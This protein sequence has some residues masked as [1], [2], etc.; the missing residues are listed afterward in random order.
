MSKQIDQ[1]YEPTKAQI[2][3]ALLPSS[4]LAIRNMAVGVAAYYLIRTITFIN[5]PI[6]EISLFAF[7][8]VL[9][10]AIIAWRC[11]RGNYSPIEQNLSSVALATALLGNSLFN[12]YINQDSLQINLVLFAI[13]ATTL[14]TIR[15][16]VFVPMFILSHLGYIYLIADVPSDIRQFFV[17][18][19]VAEMTIS[20]VFFSSRY[21]AL[22]QQVR[23][24]LIVD[25]KAADL[26][27]TSAAKDVF[28]ANITH[29]LRTPLTG[30]VGTIDLLSET[31]LD[32]EQRYLASVAKRSARI[33]LTL[34]NDILDLAKLDDGKL[35]IKPSAVDPRK[36]TQDVHDTLA[37]LAADK[38]LTFDIDMP[39]DLPV[40]LVDETRLGQI[41]FNLIGNA[42]KYTAS[43]GIFVEFHAEKSSD[44]LWHC[45]W[46][47]KDT[48]PGIDDHARHRLFQRY[49]QFDD[50]GKQTVNTGTG[51]GLSISR[52]LARNMGGDVS[53]EPRLPGGSCFALSLKLP[54]A[55][56][57]DVPIANIDYRAEL[58]G[59]SVK[60][61]LAEDTKINQM[62]IQK[63]L[64]FD[65][66]SFDVAND[67]REAVDKVAAGE[68]YDLILMDIIM[69]E[70]DGQEATKQILAM[71]PDAVIV[72][73]SANVGG[74]SE[75]K[76]AG[77]GFKGSISKPINQDN[78]YE[79]LAETLCKSD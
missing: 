43:G 26:E 68:V 7:V 56:T 11:R 20:I 17:F 36:I 54:E 3:T 46:S 42:I 19:M 24:Q 64:A 52:S 75:S 61:L 62:I 65:R 27:K 23:L 14:A 41:L 47:V 8:S 35:K 76:Y 59:L 55:K 51:L 70:M 45:V 77:L 50:Q 22:Y 49:E 1:A 44:D 40:L 66:W 78:L 2:K 67:G 33:L 58:A 4:S 5:N 32:D 71:T 72:A 38:V 57:S 34:I 63:M 16:S 53:Y 25:A 69:P 10:A 28:F 9:I 12:Y 60:V 18:F 31:K 48:G 21:N 73:I 30:V 39:K 37:P 13:L 15:I 29:E 6:S 74:D 79:T